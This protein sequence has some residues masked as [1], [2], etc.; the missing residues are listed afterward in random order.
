MGRPINLEFC[1]N[2]EFNGRKRRIKN[3]MITGSCN[4][5]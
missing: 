2:A 5:K 4:K 1:E 3:E